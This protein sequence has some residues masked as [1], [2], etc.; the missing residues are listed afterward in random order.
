MSDQLPL[1]APV[2]KPAPWR[3]FACEWYSGTRCHEAIPWV[4]R[5]PRAPAC[6]R[7]VVRPPL[8]GWRAK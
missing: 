5:S 2:A 1:F 4:T 7:L 3:C 8:R 6:E